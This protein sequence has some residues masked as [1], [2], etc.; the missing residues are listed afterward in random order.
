MEKDRKE[1][2]ERIDNFERRV[3]ESEE[4]KREGEMLMKRIERLEK[5]R[6]W[7]K[8]ERG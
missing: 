2:M 5:E 4:E 6:G 1:M 8:G 3:K 7:S